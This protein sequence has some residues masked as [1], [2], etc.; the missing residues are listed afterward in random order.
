MEVCIIGGG[1]SGII[2]SKVCLENNL[3]PFIL[4]KS[5]AP[6]GLWKG[7][8]GEIGVW[9][10]ITANNSKYITCFSDQLWDESIP[11]YPTG[12]QFLEYLS[13]YI[14]KHN[15]F[16]YI[17][18]NCEVN[19]IE[20]HQSG[21]HVTWHQNSVI[22]NKIFKYVIIASGRNAYEN[23][24]FKNPEIFQG[25]I[26]KG[27]SYR[28]P[29]V[30]ENKNVLVIGRSFTA[31]DIAFD[32]LSTAKSV[33]Q[34]YRKPY[35]VVRKY[36]DNIPSDFFIY[37]VFESEQTRHY[38]NDSVQRVNK[39]KRILKLMGNPG[40]VL[41]EWRINEE[42]LDAD[43]FNV[44]VS[45]D[46][47]YS[48][49]SEG[50]IQCIRGSVKDLYEN[51]VVLETGERIEADTIV[52]A[53]GYESN[54]SYLSQ[55]IKEII[56]YNQKDKLVPVVLYR[57]VCHPDLPGLCFV[58]NFSNHAPGFEV[59][60][61]LG[62]KFLIGQLNADPEEMRKGIDEEEFIR[63]NG[64][65]LPRAYDAVG[66]VKECLKNVGVSIDYDFIRNELLFANGPLLPCFYYMNR[67]GQEEI[68]RK[69]VREIKEKYP[70]YSFS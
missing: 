2:S 29:S 33:A 11:D 54:Y 23:I 16:Q 22:F 24:P 6:G 15:L 53:M 12:Q 69:A 7:A 31:S 52:V 14:Q 47:Y 40:D 25:S 20:K 19:L 57:A 35:L 38:L 49:V 42:S 46:E 55:E 65:N 18:N 67:P 9:R 64:K 63:K 66:Y 68:C 61:E 59:E 4:N 1:F 45:G 60:A 62:V 28:E 30:F 21:Y 34:I 41:E 5:S 58:G 3:T 10:S 8:S 44:S 39:C 36:L 26:I 13:S 43:H 50:K 17:H 32:A 27:G 51:G 70:G 48:A 37:S 56:K